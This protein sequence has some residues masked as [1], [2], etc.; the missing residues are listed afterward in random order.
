MRNKIQPMKPLKLALKSLLPRREEL[1][2]GAVAMVVIVALNALMV[3]RHYDVFAHNTRGGWW[4][5]YLGHFHVSG[6]DPILYLVMSAWKV[7]F[8]GVRHP[9]LLWMLW[10]A[11]ELNKWLMEAAGLN[12]AQLITAAMLT[13]ADAASFIIMH[14]LL[15][16]VVGVGRGDAALLSALFFS[17]AYVMVPLVVPDHFAFSMTLLLL[18]LYV[19]GRRLRAGRPLSGALTV[20]LFVVTAGVTLSNGVKVLLAQWATCGRRFFAWRNLLCVAVAPSALLLWAAF[21]VGNVPKERTEADVEADRAQQRRLGLPPH[22]S[23]TPEPMGTTGF[24]NWTDASTPRLAAAVENIFGES[25]QLHRDHLLGDVWFTRPA[26]VRYRWA[27][28]YVAEALL[29]ALFA[30]GVWAGRRD[31]FLRLCLLWFAFDMA[32]TL[33]L[34]FGLNEAFIFGPHWLFVMP[35]AMAFA[36]RACAGRRLAALRCAIAALALWLWAWNGT[37]FVGYLLE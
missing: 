31:R 14:R 20:A 11:A 15:R 19:A 32:L 9:L 24:L 5:M 8:S 12:C 36:L 23:D 2:P 27:A 4:A 35:L 16:D 25:L 1:L 29:V 3:A 17:F 10:P 7:L 22:A 18:T 37:L 33:G 21:T 6:Y 26:I 28:S 34:G 13:A 30:L